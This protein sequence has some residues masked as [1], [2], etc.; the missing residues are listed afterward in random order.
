MRQEVA[1]RFQMLLV[2]WSVLLLSVGTGFPTRH[3]NVAHKAHGHPAHSGGVQYVPE[4]LE[5]QNQYRVCCLNHTATRG[6]GRTPST[7]PLVFFHSG[8]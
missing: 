1:G 6:G 7:A 3:K 4:T 5:Q 2:L 8:A